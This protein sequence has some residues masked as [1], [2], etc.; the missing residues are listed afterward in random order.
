MDLQWYTLIALIALL[1]CVSSCLWHFYRLIRLGRGKDYSR[2]AGEVPP[3]IRYAF[4][5]AMSPARKESALLHLPTYFAGLIYHSGTFLAFFLFF[6]LAAGYPPNSPISLLLMGYLTLSGLSG[7]GILVRRIIQRK[8]R[9]L[10]NPDDYIS[11]LLVTGFHFLSAAALIMPSWYPVYFLE[12]SAL[13][14]YLPLGKLKH[15]V[16]FFAAR[17]YLGYFYGW[18]GVWP[19]GKLNT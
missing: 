15:T 5:G 11:N 3:A 10:S 9:S 6:F 17:Y 18:R 19:P 13:A 1:I 14:L 2:Q 4:T 8:I 12:F 7:I 16:Y